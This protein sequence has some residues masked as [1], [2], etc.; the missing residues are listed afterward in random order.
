MFYISFFG[1][2]KKQEQAGAKFCCAYCNMQYTKKES[3]LL[4]VKSFHPDK[5]PQAK[6][7]V[8][9]KPK[10]S[11]LDSPIKSKELTKIINSPHRVPSAAQLAQLHQKY[12][13]IDPTLP[14]GWRVEEKKRENSKHVDRYFLCPDG[15]RR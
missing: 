3:L 13:V 5:G 12:N 4:H 15:S 6:S 1:T 7:Y 2:H 11:F 10:P 8:P 9:I 14:E